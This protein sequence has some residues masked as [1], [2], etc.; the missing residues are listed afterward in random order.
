MRF[1]AALTERI[2][3][4]GRVHGF[5]RGCIVLVVPVRERLP[6]ATGAADVCLGVAARE[7]LGTIVG[8]AYETGF[9]FN[10]RLCSRDGGNSLLFGWFVKEQRSIRIDDERW[11]SARGFGLVAGS[12]SRLDFSSFGLDRRSAAQNSRSGKHGK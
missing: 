10:C 8:M 5:R 11:R 2:N 4:V 3:F 6:V 7:R 1:M 12:G 9:V